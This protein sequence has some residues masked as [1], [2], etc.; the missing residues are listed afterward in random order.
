MNCHVTQLCVLIGSHPSRALINVKFPREKFWLPIIIQSMI[1][2]V[3]P[4]A[5]SHSSA[6]SFSVRVARENLHDVEVFQECILA[7][8]HR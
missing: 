8:I 4:L 7:V 6:E 5:D 3:R 2:L 1:V